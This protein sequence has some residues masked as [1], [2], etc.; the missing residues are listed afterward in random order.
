MR[1]MGLIPDRSRPVRFPNHNKI[2]GYRI[3]GYDFQEELKEY[4]TEGFT[5]WQKELYEKYFSEVK[6]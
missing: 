4:M 6:S 1:P 2:Y 5:E 3:W